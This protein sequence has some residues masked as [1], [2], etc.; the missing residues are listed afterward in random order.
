MKYY[1]LMILI[2]LFTACSSK[3]P[4]MEH[5][6]SNAQKYEEFSNT[7][8]LLTD[9]EI[10]FFTLNNH[11]IKIQ[12]INKDSLSENKIVS[13]S[14]NKKSVPVI[15]DNSSNWNN[16]YIITLSQKIKKANIECTLTDGTVIHKSIQSY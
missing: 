16:H 10:A 15:E 11:Q 13:C 2:P 6:E 4:G 8:Y 7:Q 1:H 14:V 3:N 12:L 9:K 5:L